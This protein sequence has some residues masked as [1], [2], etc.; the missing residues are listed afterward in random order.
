MGGGAQLGAGEGKC[1]WKARAVFFGGG[2]TKEMNFAG[3]QWD[4]PF[5]RGDLNRNSKSYELESMKQ[6]PALPTLLPTCGEGDVT[7][8]CTAADRHTKASFPLPLLSSFMASF[9]SRPIPIHIRCR[10]SFLP[11]FLP[12]RRRH[13]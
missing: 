5:Q 12:S 9:H 4:V 11:S 3:R 13:P 8:H 10:S 2:G 7:V 6:S 1:P